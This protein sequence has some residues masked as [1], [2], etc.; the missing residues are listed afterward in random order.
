MKFIT[1]KKF[2]QSLPKKRI[3][4]GALFFNN[5]NELLIVK[6]NYKDH[7][8]IPGGGVD[9]DESPLEGCKREVKEEINLAL[10]NFKLIV[11][12]Y[13]PAKG[14]KNEA[15]HFIF[16]GGV[17]SEKQIKKIKLSEEELVEHKFL[18]IKDVLPLLGENM[19][20]KLPKCL[21]AIKNN[22]TVYLEAGN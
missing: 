11:V 7:W 12:D 21:A 22:I 6:P 8:L 1:G 2:Y 5:K 4:A 20:R 10:D 13:S 9:A 19:R 17:L 14:I 15:L 16:F 18:A 3:S